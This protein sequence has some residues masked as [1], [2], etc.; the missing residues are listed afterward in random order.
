[1]SN[2]ILS[3]DE[4]DALLGGVDDG[5]IDTSPD[6]AEFDGEHDQ[7]VINATWGLGE[8]IVGGQVTPDSV[9]VD[10]S[11]QQ[12]LLRE[13]ATKTIMTVRTDNGTEDR[14]VPQ[15]QQDQ[16]VLD[17]TTAI[18][19]ACYGAQIEAHYGLPVD[20]EWAIADNRIAIL[21]ARPITNLPPAPLKDVRWEPP[22]PGTV[23]MRRQV[24]EHMPEPLSPLF[25]ELYLRDGLYHSMETLGVFLSDLSGFEIE[26]RAFIDPPFAATV[27]GYAYSI[28]SFNFSPKLIPIAL[29][30]YVKVLPKMIRHLVPRWRD[31]SLDE[32]TEST[33]SDFIPR[34]MADPSAGPEQKLIQQTVLDVLSR[35]IEEEL[36]EKQKQALIAVRVQGMPLEEVARRMDSNRNA[37]YKLLHDARQRLKQKLFDEGLSP[38]EILAAFE[39]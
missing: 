20:I 36:T 16:P 26:L 8:A 6:T 39:M 22:R 38:Q 37:L 27:N 10:K 25:D 30:M 12:I 17:D 23:W 34:M 35:V 3:Q 28:A 5:V 19:L 2:D 11:N 4:V 15:S 32:M 13:T 29:R 9:I 24:V 21:Q 14:P 18:E 7:I 33:E 31:V 1:M